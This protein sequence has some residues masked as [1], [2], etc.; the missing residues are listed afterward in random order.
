MEPYLLPTPKKKIHT[1]KKKQTVIHKIEKFKLLHSTLINQPSKDRIV[2]TIIQKQQICYL[3]KRNSKFKLTPRRH[4]V[5]ELCQSSWLTS[6]QSSP[7]PCKMVWSPDELRFGS[8]QL[9]GSSVPWREI[10][11]QI[12]CKKLI[13][14]LSTAF[15]FISCPSVYTTSTRL[16]RCRLI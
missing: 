14:K 1:H 6:V 15:L 12:K 4:A 11:E 7:Y 5:M 8:R 13:T 2:E 9:G 16:F 10:P 3:K